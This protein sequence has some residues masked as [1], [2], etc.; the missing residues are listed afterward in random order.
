MAQWHRAAMTPTLAT[1]PQDIEDC[2]QLRRD[3]FVNEQGFTEESEFDDI[4]RT[5]Q[6]LILR[7]GDSCIGTARIFR[8]GTTGK[9]GRICVAQSHRG[10]GLGAALVRFAIAQF[11]ADPKVSDAYLSAQVQALP[12]YEALGFI[13]KG[14]PY[15]D[16]HVPHLD[17]FRQ[18]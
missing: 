3:V 4:D 16:E 12:F 5:C 17:M 1:T 11:E 14:E 8:I 15:L 6:H 9:I 10:K 2:M 7:D 18:L 13:A